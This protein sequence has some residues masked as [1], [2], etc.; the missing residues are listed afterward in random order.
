MNCQWVKSSIAHLHGAANKRQ[1]FGDDIYVCE[2][3]EKWIG[4][5]SPDQRDRYFEQSNI[6]RM[7]ANMKLN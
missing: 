4:K 7:R 3:C 6:G 1:L 5:C 2:L